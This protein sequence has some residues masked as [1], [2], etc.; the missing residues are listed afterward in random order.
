MLKENYEVIKIHGQNHVL[1]ESDRFNSPFGNANYQN[2]GKALAGV[3]KPEQTLIE[4]LHA[5]E[6][7]RL[8]AIEMRKEALKKPKKLKAA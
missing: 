4:W 1:I 5:K 8:Q 3:L 7:R 2:T 6:E